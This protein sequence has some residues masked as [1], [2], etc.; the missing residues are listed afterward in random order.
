MRSFSPGEEKN[1]SLLFDGQCGEDFFFWIRFDSIKFFINL[2]GNA[3]KF[4]E[5][6]EPWRRRQD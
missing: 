1:V 2:I 5:P 4:T 6:A 3:I